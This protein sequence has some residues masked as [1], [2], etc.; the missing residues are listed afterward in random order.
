MADLQA[1]PADAI[2]AAEES[3]PTPLRLP[4]WRWILRVLLMVVGVGFASILFYNVIRRLLPLIVLLVTSLF[5][6]FALEPAVSYLSKRGM[7]RGVATFLIMLGVALVGVVML[8][9]LVPVFVDQLV[10]LVQHG[11]EILANVTRYARE[12]FGLDVSAESL[13]EALNNANTSL[14]TFSANIAGNV[15]GVGAALVAA[16]FRLLT[17]AL[18]TFYLVADGP[19]FRRMLCSL[20]PPRQQRTVLDTWEVAIDKTGAYLYSRVVLAVFSGIGTY[21]VLRLLSVPYALPLAF[22]MG[23]VSQ[24]IPTVGTYIAMALPLLVALV[25]G[26]GDAVILLIYFSAY[27]QI[28]NYVLSP[29]VTSRTMAI[30]PALAFGAAIAGASISGVVG[31]LLA[32]PAAAIVQAVGSSYIH[33]HE[34]METALTMPE[35]ETEGPPTPPKQHVRSLLQRF[36]AGDRSSVD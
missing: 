30:H 28:E 25:Q 32:L 20:L 36:R 1:Q 16:I 4:P 10:S 22:W 34:V 26:P 24:F 5:L 29:R 35:S 31:A 7:R 23:L 12:W 14:T 18:F 11:P 19:R 9:L 3:A 8:V 15:F 13:Q 2:P 33:R 6:S 17:I 21:A 27:Q